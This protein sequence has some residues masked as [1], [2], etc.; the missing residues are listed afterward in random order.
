MSVLSQEKEATTPRK[1]PPVGRATTL[2][3]IAEYVGV[4]A[5]A[6]S[7][8][9]NNSRS[10]VR[11][12]LDTRQRI[13]DAARELQY[14]PNR[15]ARSLRC[16]RTDIIGFYSEQGSAFDPQYPFYGAIL[17]GLLQGCGDHQKN[18]LIHGTLPERG[19]EDVLQELMNGQIDGLVLYARR[20]T[21]LIERLIESHLPVVTMADEVPGL[22]CVT[23][24]DVQ[25]GRL[26]AGY[27][28]DK[29]YREVMYRVMDEEL[30]SSIQ[31]RVKGFQEEAA[32]RGLNVTIRRSPKE[33]ITE[34]DRE[35]LF[36]PGPR[37]EVIAS[38]SDYA[39][40]GMVDFCEQH[41]LKVPGDI[42][43]TGFDGFVS[44]LRPARHLT[45]VRAPWDEVAR[46]AVKL[47]VDRCEGKEVPMQT[48]L[49]VQL[50]AGNTA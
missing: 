42:A 22:P 31:L 8:V 15:V 20:V 30:P 49:P 39:A 43:V 14:R 50:V 18:I 11:V 47:L 38:F 25:G 2:A 44:A 28:A 32:R 6:A 29:G 19:E 34:D 7:V 1:A 26:L 48:F 37:P 9:L 17:K 46:T 40:D 12:S 5:V 16:Q 21:P 35:I 45:T 3:D 27:L 10:Q 33:E 13:L 36:G 4:S 23:V 41:G 24:D